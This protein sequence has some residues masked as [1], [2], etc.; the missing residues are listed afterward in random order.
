MK[1]RFQL[2]RLRQS[3]LAVW[4]LSLVLAVLQVPAKEALAQQRSALVDGVDAIGITVSDM[5]SCR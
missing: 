4:L 3:L 1:Q 5:G 2:R